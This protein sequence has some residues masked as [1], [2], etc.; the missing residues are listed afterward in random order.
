M[1]FTFI[2]L[3]GLFAVKAVFAQETSPVSPAHNAV[4]DTTRVEFFW[5]KAAGASYYELQLA[6]DS[7]FSVNVVT[8]SSIV[9]NQYT[10]NVSS[11]NTQYFWHVRYHNGTTFSPWSSFR[12]FYVFRPSDI[13]GLQ[14]WL[15]AD[16]GVTHTSGRISAWADKSANAYVAQQATSTKQPYLINP[17]RLD[18][19]PSVF[20]NGTANCLRI[21]SV[22]LSS[23]DAVSVITFFKKRVITGTEQTMFV[24]TDDVYSAANGFYNIIQAGSGK[25][26]VG[27]KGNAGYNQ[28]NCTNPVDTTYNVLSIVYN[29]SVMPE[30]A[31]YLNSS[32]Y[33]G[34]YPFQADNSGNF[35]STSFNI[36]SFDQNYSYF[37]GEMPEMVI[38]DKQ[39]STSERNVVENYMKAH[40]F[41]P[42]NL[43]YDTLIYSFKPFSLK[44]GLRFSTYLWSNGS[45]VDSISVISSGTYAVSATDL[46]GQ[47]SKDTVIISF[48][49][50]RLTYSNDTSICMGS[51]I[52][53]KTKI[54]NDADYSFLWSGGSTDSVLTVTTSGSYFVKVTDSLGYFTYSD[55][56][57]IQVD[58]LS[59][60]VGLGPDTSFCSGN[61]ISLKPPLPNPL[62]LNY[63]W[64][65]G[66]HDT[67][68]VISSTGLY[69]VTVTNIIGCSGADSINITVTGTAP[70]VDFSY[71]G[72]CTGDTIFFTDLTV[73]AD[74]IKKWHWDF[75]NGDTSNLQNP[76]KIYS[77]GGAFQVSLNAYTAGGCGNSHTK[78]L[79]VYNSPIAA[80]DA[81]TGCLSAPYPFVDQSTAAAG[82]TINSWAWNFGDSQTS[83][84]QNPSHQ[85]TSSGNFNV[86]L[87]II[88]TKGCDAVITKP[89]SIVNAVSPATPATLI[90]PPQ[91]HLSS[92]SGMNFSWDDALNAKQYR[93]EIASDTLFTNI[94]YKTALIT[95]T[96]LNVS[97]LP[98]A[99][100]YFWRIKSYNICKDSTLS[101][102]RRFY[103][104]NSTSIPD[105]KLWLMA[106]SAITLISGKVSL[107]SDLSGNGNDCSQTSSGSRPEYQSVSAKF[108]NNPSVYFDGSNDF[109]NGSLI[110]GVDSSYTLFIIT[111]GDAQ[112]GDGKLIFSINNY[113]NGVWL[114]RR[115]DN[116][117]SS[118]LQYAGNGFYTLYSP[119][120]TIPSLGY[121][122]K[123]ITADKLLGDH[124][125]LYINSQFQDGTNNA[126]A[127]AISTNDIYKLCADNG[128]GAYKGN[129]AEVIMYSRSLDNNESSNVE[130]YLRYKY[131]GP[132]VNLGPDINV[133][134]GMCGINLDAGS[135]FINYQWSTGDTT[136]SIE[137][138]QNGS[139][140]VSA[141]NIF[142]EV[143]SDTISVV[144]PTFFVNDTTFCLG[145]T[146]S[147][148]VNPGQGYTYL[149]LPDS[150]SGQTFTTN[151]PGAYS[152]TVFDSTGCNRTKYF[153]LTAD[154][155][156]VVASLGPDRKICQGE[157][158]G[159]VSGAQQATAY[160]W[161]NGS[162]NNMILINDAFG[163]SPS[164]SV[165]VSNAN[166]CVAVDSIQLMINGIQPNVNFSADSVCF[167]NASHFTDLSSVSP[168]FVIASYSWDFGD[169]TSSS[170]ANPVHTYGSDG[171]Y[172]VVHMVITDSGCYRSIT[173][174]VKVFSVPQVHYLPNQGCNDAVIHF[175][176]QTI[177]PVGNLTQWLWNFGDPL[178][179]TSD[180]STT[181]NPVHVFD[182]AGTYIVKLKA[183]S[184]AGC[185]D[186]VAA[187]VLIRHAPAI[188]YAY[189]AGCSGQMIYFN[190]ITPLQPWEAILDY[191]WDFGDGDSAF[192]SNPCH[193]FNNAGTYNVTMTI[194]TLNGCIL[195]LTKTVQVGDVPVPDFTFTGNCAGSPTTF[196]DNSSAS[197]GSVVSWQWNFDGEGS[198]NQQNP[199][200]LFP[201][202]GI[203]NVVLIV[204]TNL[205]CIDSVSIP[206][207]VS[208]SPVAGFTFS[209]EYGVPPLNVAFT[210]TS[211]L[212]SNYEWI[213]GDGAT[214]FTVNPSHL[215]DIQ[216][217]FHV[218][219]TAYNPM[220]CFDTVG[221]N[222]YVLPTSVDIAVTRVYTVINNN[223]L[224]ISADIV[225]LGTRKINSIDLSARIENGNT[226]HETWSGI[227]QEG[228]GIQYFFNAGFQIPSGIE[229]NYI[230]INALINGL[231]DDK[232]INNELCE[233]L[234][235]GFIVPEPYPNP[236]KDV[237]NISWI[238]PFEDELTVIIYNELGEKIK[239]VFNGQG[240]KGFS[241][242]A[243]DVSAFHGGVYTYRIIF[244]D[245]TEKRK[246]VKL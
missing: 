161:S 43:G 224:K 63:T 29:K 187:S 42:V 205:N 71:T 23:S 37:N 79:N 142:G 235:D 70:T 213:F 136:Q 74:T 184:I 162:G 179:G 82:D 214:D 242:I 128:N 72:G 201:D 121:Y 75:G 139:Y 232:P 19:L 28:I 66:T 133:A 16:K 50:A 226:I 157:Y 181:Q 26:L 204:K 243:L 104:F 145:D 180:T 68:L 199:V 125:N 105:M 131:A 171:I 120:G 124:V 229:L 54:G 1:R 137:V 77:S 206:V 129:I 22:N 167:G 10:Y 209:P 57:N 67:S 114:L 225:N 15:R 141:T 148:T 92:A 135:R 189:T 212:A 193:I 59:A 223:I 2:F 177:C 39:L 107:W 46:F 103:I 64:N 83:S 94:I 172:N 108:K 58:S 194:R 147:L 208:P 52:Q 153:T 207:S 111:S 132:P 156:S 34:S 230:C 246:F 155:F 175:S 117:P 236:V 14:L 202:T 241:N 195:S 113:T 182:T 233:V 9:Q 20:Y 151:I 85:Y 176:D 48:P 98:A 200:F 215:Y 196:T 30:V 13:T 4:V 238:L 27:V 88:T 97:T 56:I 197:T 51:A 36:G 109:L 168:P 245:K 73:S 84:L 159:L 102:I 150:V 158:L 210:N 173:K 203:Y 31:V 244:R 6:S 218:I 96:N 211:I 240:K 45:S 62:L 41:P 188:D 25:N 60:K 216:G 174:T 146:V 183:T 35:T 18:G 234:S 5:N 149:W 44:A 99:S 112:T 81:D 140:I 164:Y 95:D 227:L 61:A 166:G 78:S 55:T 38:Y 138:I 186:S 163:T 33:S 185:T 17:S 101:L 86:S 11:S 221:A 87:T 116:A 80:F 49:N 118:C 152:L 100:A 32:A 220:G 222:V 160:L 134:Y 76:Y 192:I 12:K 91:A 53:L 110:S 219:L 217:V 47:N 237:L 123:I 144:F 191:Y 231:T 89:L 126:S 65:N 90:Y 239:E 119:A 40:Y 3:L 127:V 122:P 143:S 93:L 169:S 178:S 69:S 130:K 154:S 190:D 198:S 21:P 106:D 165:T 228:E 24:T 8:L 170:V 115:V 7:L